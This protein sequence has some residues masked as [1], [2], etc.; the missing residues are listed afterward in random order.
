MFMLEKNG[1]SFCDMTP[2]TLEKAIDEVCTETRDML[3]GLLSSQPVYEFV[4]STTLATFQD[5]RQ[6]GLREAALSMFL[7]MICDREITHRK[8]EMT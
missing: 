8:T 2:D 5:M 3:R 4:N 6:K 1:K 7:V